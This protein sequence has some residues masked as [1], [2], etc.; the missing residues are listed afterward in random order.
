M[1]PQTKNN[2]D[3]IIKRRNLNRAINFLGF[4][5]EE[6][7]PN[8]YNACDLFVTASEW[9][10]FGLPIIEA[11]ACGKPV[12]ARDAYAMTEHI[13]GSKAG[14]LFRDKSDLGQRIIKVLNNIEI[15]SKNS[16]SY[17]LQFSWEKNVEK[18]AVVYQSVLSD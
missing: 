16:R 8:Y 2:L 11:F 6:K 12:V 9:E 10:G 1:R 17:A 14:E 15:Y 3:R 13:E 18:T 7:L 4:I 5:D